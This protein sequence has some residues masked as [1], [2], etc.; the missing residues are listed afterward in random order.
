MSL[1][2]KFA[3]KVLGSVFD[4][5]M[6]V[7][8]GISLGLGVMGV[9]PGMM[10]AENVPMDDSDRA[11]HEVAMQEYTSVLDFLAENEPPKVSLKPSSLDYLLEKQGG[12]QPEPEESKYSD[13]ELRELSKKF[14]V[15]VVIDQR[16]NEEQ[17][18]D[19]IQEFESRVG[20]FEQLTG[21]DEPDYN[22]LD[23]G[24]ERVTRYENERDYAEQVISGSNSGNNMDVVLGTG[25]VLF[26]LFLSMGG[27]VN[28][29]RRRLQNWSE[30]K[31]Y[32][33][34]PKMPH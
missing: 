23:Q 27:L 26:A 10:V 13:A 34:P 31:T 17:K 19:L 1:K 3:N 15:S 28:A 32:K 6:D 12:Q 25:G 22:D 18:Y 30:Q 8:L 2:Q 11:G 29:N 33:K 16:L 21:L 5:K 4:Q 9:L 14:G 24:M 20:G 7:V